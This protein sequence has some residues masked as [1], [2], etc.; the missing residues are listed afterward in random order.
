VC[1]HFGARLIRP[2]DPI[3]TPA[4]MMDAS[5]ASRVLLLG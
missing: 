5:S 3:A 1:R 2:F 4:Y